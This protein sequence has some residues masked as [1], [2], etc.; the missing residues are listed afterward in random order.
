M[1]KLSQLK[2]ERLRNTMEVVIAGKE[3]VIEI[4]NPM[5]DLRNELVKMLL[6][7]EDK[8]DVELGKKLYTKLFKECTNIEVDVDLD[9][10]LDNPSEIVSLVMGELNEIVHEL[11]TQSLTLNIMK[12]N[13]LIKIALMNLIATKVDTYY[14]I[15]KECELATDEQLHLFENKDD[16]SGL[17]ELMKEFNEFEAKKKAPKKKSTKKTTKKKD[18]IKE[19]VKEEDK[20]E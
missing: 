18:E 17:V 2:T 8:D 4:Y 7:N 3:E 16:L 19:E 15:N 1:A 13:D 11:Q 5:D 9:E 14:K 20:K 6:D 12:T 10:M